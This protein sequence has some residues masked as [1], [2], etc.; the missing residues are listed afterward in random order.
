MA[1]PL[2]I[3]VV[4]GSQ[5]NTT[6]FGGL[7]AM[8]TAELDYTVNVLLENFASSNTSVGDLNITGGSNTAGAFVDTRRTETLGTHPASGATNTTTTTFYQNTSSASETGMIRPVSYVSNTYPMQEQTDTELNATIIATALSKIADSESYATGQYYIGT[9]A[10]AGGTWTSKG[11][12]TDSYIAAAGAQVTYSLYRKT[13]DG[14]SP[15]VV[16][17]IRADGA[18]IKEMTD[19]NLLTLVPRLRNRVVA[20]GVGTYAFQASAPGTGTWITVSAEITDQMAE[21]TSQNYTSQFTGTFGRAFGRTYSAQYTRQFARTF[22]ANYSRSFARVYSAAYARQF[23][24]VYSAGYGRA[25]GRV[26]AG[27]YAR[28]FQRVYSDN[29][30]RQFTRQYAGQYARSTPGPNYSDGNYARA[31]P[32]PQYTVNYARS[33][34]GPNYSDG[35]YARARPGPQYTVNYVRNNPGPAYTAGDYARARPGPNYTVNYA[36][37]NPG[38]TYSDGQYARARPGLLTQ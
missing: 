14:T 6:N 5:P 28:T 13:D 25:F 35:N 3:K 38:P 29:Y 11:T 33:T 15:A 27:A 21:S 20:T 19:A 22:S 23:Q 4:G 12:F 30:L 7:Q 37:N 34:P 2:K 10:P 31:T 18:S 9:S 1:N 24:R 17:P 36:R 16:R 8:T 32:G 26:Y